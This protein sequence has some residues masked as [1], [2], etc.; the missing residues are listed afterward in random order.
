LLDIDLYEA[1]LALEVHSSNTRKGGLMGRLNAHSKTGYVQ[2]YLVDLFA[3]Q[4]VVAD[5]V[6]C[7]IVISD[8]AQG[9]ID[10]ETWVLR[11]CYDSVNINPTDNERWAVTFSN[12]SQAVIATIKDALLTGRK[13]LFTGRIDSDGG[14]PPELQTVT[15]WR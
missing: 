11:D 6:Y 1:T 3:E 2:S 4:A 7:S 8:D 9:N 12:L 10:P 14:K 5:K 15:I 13:V